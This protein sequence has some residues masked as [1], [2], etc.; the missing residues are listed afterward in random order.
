MKMYNYE[1]N[2]KVWV[3]GDNY[4]IVFLCRTLKTLEI[5]NIEKKQE[6]WVQGYVYIGSGVEDM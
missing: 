6:A 4:M 5:Y 1:K 2:G 3:R